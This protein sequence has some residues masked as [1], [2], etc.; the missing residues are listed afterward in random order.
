MSD[1]YYQLGKD[2][3]HETYRL[4][5]ETNHPRTLVYLAQNMTTPMERASNILKQIDDACEPK[6]KPQVV[7]VNNLERQVNKLQA[8][9][10]NP[11]LGKQDLQEVAILEKIQ[12]LGYHPK[13]LPSYINGNAGIKKEVREALKLNP[14]FEGKSVFNK[15]WDRLLKDCAISYQ[16]K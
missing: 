3:D 4:M 9:P 16:E 13:E 6:P 2:F 15:A 1:E 10:I 5:K 8:K 14:L 7:E 12:E 11:Q